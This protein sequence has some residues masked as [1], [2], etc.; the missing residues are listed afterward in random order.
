[1]ASQKY[2]L[3][4]HALRRAVGRDELGM[5]RFELPAAASSSLSYSQI[6]NRR[7]RIDVIPPIVIANLF[8]EPLNLPFDRFSPRR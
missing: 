7:R 3:A 1:M 6:G 5:S 2:R 8:A 4:A